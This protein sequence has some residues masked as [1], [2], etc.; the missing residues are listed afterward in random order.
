MPSGYRH[1]TRHDRCQ[2]QALKKSG[3]SQRAIAAET[4]RSQSTVSREIS[5]NSGQRGYRHGQAD[6]LGGTA[7]GGVVCPPADDLSTFH[8]YNRSS[9]VPDSMACKSDFDISRPIRSNGSGRPALTAVVPGHRLP[10]SCADASV[11]MTPPESRAP[12][13]PGAS[14][15]DWPTVSA[16]RCPRRRRCSVT[17]SPARPTAGPTP[18]WPV[19][20]R[21]SARSGWIRSPTFHCSTV[22]CAFSMSETVNWILSSPLKHLS[23]PGNGCRLKGRKPTMRPMAGTQ[24]YTVG[25]PRAAEARSPMH[26]M[27]WAVRMRSRALISTGRTIPDAGVS[28]VSR[29]R[30]DSSWTRQAATASK[31]R[32]VRGPSAVSS[33]RSPMQVPRSTVSTR[34]PVAQRSRYILL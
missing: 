5:R 9:S 30:R 1:L 21:T 18:T 26:G 33:F 25:G 22:D 29:A 10:A 31:A 6:G 12:A 8:T 13:P 15:T 2:I 7:P 24:A 17:G 32:Q 34:R 28:G 16:F 11:G 14:P 27:R 19:R 23:G 20:L 3:L 4:D